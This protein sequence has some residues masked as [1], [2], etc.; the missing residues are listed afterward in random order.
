MKLECDIISKKRANIGS[1]INSNLKFGSFPIHRVKQGSKHPH[2]VVMQGQ[3]ENISVGL[4]TKNPR[5]DLIKVFYSNGKTGYMKRTATR[6][7][8]NK[9]DKK[10]LNYYVDKQSE[11]IAYRIAMNKLLS[12][13]GKSKK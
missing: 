12:G 3:K 9:Y 5:G 6:Q 11:E 13:I 8:T 10:K 7:S 1:N 4:T 2:I